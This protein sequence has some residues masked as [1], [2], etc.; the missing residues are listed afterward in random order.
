[1][2]SDH[3]LVGVGLGNYPRKLG[4]Y[5]DTTRDFA[6]NPAV[7]N[8][9]SQPLQIAAEEGLL[10]LLAS[11]LVCVLAVVHLVRRLPDAKGDERA[12][13]LAVLG[14]LLGCFLNLQLG[15]SLLEPSV[16]HVFG[17]CLGA[18]LGLGGGRD[19]QLERLDRRGAIALAILFLVAL[20]P[21]LFREP[22]PLI[23]QRQG[24]F[25]EIRREETGR[26]D[27][28]TAVRARWIVR[29]GAGGS[30]ILEARDIQPVTDVGERVLTLEAHALNNGAEPTTVAKPLGR[31]LDRRQGNPSTFLRLRAPEGVVEGDL[32]EIRS[33]VDRVWFPSS[34]HATSRDALG[35][36]VFDPVFRD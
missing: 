9:H 28:L 4:A 21:H 19:A 16:A 32:V 26:A 34:A 30:M 23:G 24:L 3:P 11:L 17:V 35:A 18:A 6:F 36:R 31:M 14:G 5:R 20:L 10:G 29:W 25:P 1:M 22:R 33:A 2:A 27:R 13:A 8:A 12:F 7:E 15:H